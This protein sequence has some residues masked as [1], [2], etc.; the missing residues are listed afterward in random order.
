MCFVPTDPRTLAAKASDHVFAIGDA[1]DL[2]SSKAGSVAHFQSEV[3]EGNLLAVAAGK[4]PGE[5]FDGHANCFIESG[6]GKALL[7]D[8]N[9]ETDPLPG[10]F[11]VPG[12]GPLPL[13][14]QARRNHWAKLLFEWAY[15]NLVLPGRRLP[16]PAR[17]SM[18]GKHPVEPPP[19]AADSCPDCRQGESHA[20]S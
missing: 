6:K 10:N 11:P 4:S 2:P 15:W 8:F 12:I 18:A 9:Y 13:L 16:I 17:M 19:A 7:I 20:G 14:K 3:L 1:T 5:A